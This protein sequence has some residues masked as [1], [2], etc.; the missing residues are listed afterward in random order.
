MP[1]I[2]SPGSHLG[3]QLNFEEGANSFGNVKTPPV[4]SI[5]KITTAH[6]TRQFAVDV[7]HLHQHSSE[8]HNNC[9]AVIFIL[10]ATGPPRLSS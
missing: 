10:L 6:R 4:A 7:I 1:S 8:Q 2:Q 3:L 5:I 9:D